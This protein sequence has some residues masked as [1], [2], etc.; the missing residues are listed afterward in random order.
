MAEYS[1]N[2]NNVEV[3]VVW[4]LILNRIKMGVYKYKLLSAYI[5]A[6]RQVVLPS[7]LLY[8]PTIFLCA[9][10]SQLSTNW[11]SVSLQSIQSDHS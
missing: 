7:Y 9:G 10:G 6:W 1:C 5:I 8:D 3:K 4:L 11:S 2:V